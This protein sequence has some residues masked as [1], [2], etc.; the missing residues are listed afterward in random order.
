MKI[1]R[2]DHVGIATDSLKNTAPFWGDLLG[3]PHRK[4]EIVESEGVTTHIYDTGG[5]KIEL[6]TR[7]GK[8]SPIARFL[9][10]RGPGIHHLCLEVDDVRSAVEKLKANG[11]RLVN[12]TPREGAEGSRIVFIHPRSTG[13]VLVELCQKS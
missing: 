6:L 5:G 12:E 8:D 10:R 11:I 9:K 13:G 4:T 3:I 2:I 1:L 7:Y